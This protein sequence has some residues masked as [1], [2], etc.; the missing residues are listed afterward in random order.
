MQQMYKDYKDLVEFRLVYINEA[1]AADSSWSVPY[2]KELGINDHRNYGERCSTA[3]KLLT[4]KSLTIPTII[5]GMDNKVNQAY[6]A[7][8]DRVFLVRKDGKLAVAGQQGPWGFVPALQDTKTWLAAYKETGAE[9]AL[10]SAEEIEKK[11]TERPRGRR[12]GG[13]SPK[14][15]FEGMDEDKD[16]KVTKAEFPEMMRDAFDKVDADSDGVA[17]FEEFEEWIASRRRPGGS[18]GDG[19]RRGGGGRRGGGERQGDEPSTPLASSGKELLGAWEMK[20]AFQGEFIPAT[21][22]LKFEEG[23]L[24]GVWASQVMEMPMTDI[25]FK[26]GKLRFKRTM[27]PGGASL[28]FEGTVTG[29]KISGKYTGT[30]GDLESSGQRK[31]ETD[32]TAGTD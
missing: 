16:G 13:G 7:W 5:D 28:A 31:K 2:A 25:V 20:T 23:K 18:G 11:Y 22:T 32:K 4:D 10:P 26:K 9:P 21:M 6:H 30:M 3:Q 29:G 17:T 27:G 1:H 14:Q 19:E 15:M 24:T 12:R 8:P